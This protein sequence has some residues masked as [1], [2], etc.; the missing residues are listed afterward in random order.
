[1]TSPPNLRLHQF[2]YH[3]GKPRGGLRRWQNPFTKNQMISSRSPT[4]WKTRRCASKRFRQMTSNFSPREIVSEL[5]RFIIGQ[6]AAK[7]AVA[8]ALRNR[9]R[10]KQLRDE[11]RRKPTEEHPD[12]RP[13]RRR[14]DQ[15]FP[16]AGGAGER[17]VHE[18]RGDQVHRGRRCRPRCR[19]DRARPGRGR[20]RPDARAQARAGQG[21][22][23]ARRRGARAE[24]AGR[25]G[26]QRGDARMFC[27]KKRAGNS[28]TTRSSSSST[29]GAG[30][31]RGSTS[32][33]AEPAWATS[34]Q[35]M[36]GQAFGGRT[37]SAGPPSPTPTSS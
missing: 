24:G 15:D 6:N 25:G 37:G 26:R 13:H 19:T 22:R 14:Q 10:R 21:P 32:R 17:A 31:W 33:H 20:D 5:D 23:P 34:R 8:V 28:T 4:R 11:I 18:G 7:R 27:K 29:T 16:P 12:D 1:M 36:L 30:P 9:W 3:R 2:Q 35:Q